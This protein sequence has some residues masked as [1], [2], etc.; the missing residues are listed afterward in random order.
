MRV[1]ARVLDLPLDTLDPAGIESSA[2]RALQNEKPLREW[3][4]KYRRVVEHWRTSLTAEAK[5]GRVNGHR[6]AEL[7]LVCVGDVALLGANAEVFSEFTDWL[8]RESKKKVY[9]IGYANGDMGYLPTRAAY[10][11]GGYEVEVAHLFYG[12]FRPKAGG[13]ELLASAAANLIAHC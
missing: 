2:A 6:D 10:Q 8:R 13:L 5:A 11:E 1:T 7:F 4:D 12:G 9:L 3:G